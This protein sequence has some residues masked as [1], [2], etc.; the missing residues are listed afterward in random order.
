MH[1]PNSPSSRL[2]GEYKLD[3]EVIASVQRW[4]MLLPPQVMNCVTRSCKHVSFASQDPAGMKG[5]L[6]KLFST[7]LYSEWC[8][9]VDAYYEKQH[10]HRTQARLPHTDC[11]CKGFTFK[12]IS[13]SIFVM[14]PSY[15]RYKRNLKT[16]LS[17]GLLFF[18]NS[19]TSKNLMLSIP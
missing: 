10:C 2:G 6:K 1:C 14:T 9:Y 17:S 16:T 5:I 13:R 12:P 15:S 11:C 4:H 7:S 18:S 3:G 8:S 19:R